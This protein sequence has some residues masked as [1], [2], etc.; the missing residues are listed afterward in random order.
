MPGSGG[1]PVRLLDEKEKARLQGVRD[2]ALAASTRLQNKA[3]GDA[4]GALAWEVGLYGATPSDPSRMLDLIKAAK[5]ESFT[6]REIADALGEG[7][8]PPDARRVRD[9]YES[10]RK[11]DS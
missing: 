3:P 2:R 5:G 10:W 8:A 1:A 4:L 6:W 11:A 9:R 7:D